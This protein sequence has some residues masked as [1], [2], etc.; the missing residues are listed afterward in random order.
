[1]GFHT[2]TQDIYPA[3]SSFHQLFAMD[4]QIKLHELCTF[5]HTREGGYPEI[6]EKTGFPLT[7]C[8]NDGLIK[9][10]VFCALAGKMRKSCK[11]DVVVQEK[12][13]WLIFKS[14]YHGKQQTENFIY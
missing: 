9:L 10:F 14:C 2:Q 13:R 5:R 8:G 6:F 7:D 4:S 1:M 3:I 12:K 11:L